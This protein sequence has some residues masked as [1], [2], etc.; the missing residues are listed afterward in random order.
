MKAVEIAFFA[1]AVLLPL[2]GGGALLYF[3]FQGGQE[4]EV[5]MLRFPAPPVG[6]DIPDSRR[7]T[8]QVPIRFEDVTQDG[9][10]AL[11]GLAPAL[12][13]VISGQGSSRARRS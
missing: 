2:V 8:G 10:L 5:T 13:E 6:P 7:A 9:R 3:F 12:G 1:V 11:E 4:R